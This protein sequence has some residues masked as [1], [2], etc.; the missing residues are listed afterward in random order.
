VGPRII[1]PSELPRY[2]EYAEKR[3][4][5]RPGI[6]GLWQISGRQHINYDERVLLDITYIDRRSLAGDLLIIFKT[7]KVLVVHSGV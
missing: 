3:H 4:S 2:G 5:V 7:L 1:H 6:T